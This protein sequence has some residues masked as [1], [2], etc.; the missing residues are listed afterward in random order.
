M[1]L[2]LLKKRSCAKNIGMS[3]WPK[4]DVNMGFVIRAE[5]EQHAREI[6]QASGADEIRQY[7][8]GG[9]F[10]AWLNSA[11]STCEELTC[12]GDEEII[13]TDFKAG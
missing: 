5:T 13:L 12:T 10:P 9:E 1:K 7:G 11:Y 4:G 8:G 6:A 3:E 2:F